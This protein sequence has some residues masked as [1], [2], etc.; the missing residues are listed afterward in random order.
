[1]GGAIYLSEFYRVPKFSWG[2]SRKRCQEE[3]LEQKSKNQVLYWLI[4]F[5]FFVKAKSVSISGFSFL[6]C[7]VKR[8]ALEIPL[9]S[10]C[11]CPHFRISTLNGCIEV[12]C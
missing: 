4:I 1:M 10:K 9:I 5:F 2:K 6:T 3:R 12:I 7:E 8:L 11:L